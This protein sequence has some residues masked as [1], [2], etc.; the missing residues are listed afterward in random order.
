MCKISQR[1]LNLAEKIINNTAN[2]SP[3]SSKSEINS[4]TVNAISSSID[5]KSELNI[6]SSQISIEMKPGTINDNDINI[7]I[8]SFQSTF[9]ESCIQHN[10]NNNDN[11]DTISNNNNNNNNGIAITSPFINITLSNGQQPNH[12]ITF[13]IDIN[14]SQTDNNNHNIKTMMCPIQ[15]IFYFMVN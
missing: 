8:V 12:P 3:K 15:F 10:I 13:T 14:Q 4:E 11:D 9:A 5:P 1:T 6:K 7:N 2:N